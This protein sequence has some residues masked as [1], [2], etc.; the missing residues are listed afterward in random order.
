MT[1][2]LAQWGVPAGSW[3]YSVVDNIRDERPLRWNAD[4]L[5]GWWPFRSAFHKGNHAVFTR[6]VRLLEEASPP[7]I[8]SNIFTLRQN[9]VDMSLGAVGDVDRLSNS[10]YVEQSG[11]VLGLMFWR[12]SVAFAVIST[13]LSRDCTEKGNSSLCST[14]TIGS[15]NG[16]LQERIENFI[17]VAANV[18][19]L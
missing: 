9:N 1:S 5:L 11:A 15:L 18:R 6:Y 7:S 2:G 14:N 17:T 8:P 19:A 16:M 10:C 13:R 4:M 12:P 3:G